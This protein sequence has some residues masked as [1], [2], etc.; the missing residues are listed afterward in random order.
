MHMKLQ[1]VRIKYLRFFESQGHTTLPSASLVPENDPTTLFTGSGMQPLLPFLLGEKHP[2]GVRLV[3]S[4]KC[5][6]AEDID[7]IGDNRHTTFFEMLGNWSLGDYFKQEQIP[8]FFEFL[9]KKIG[10]DPSKLYVTVFA[11]DKKNNI[12][13]DME[14]VELWKKLFKKHG[15]DAKDIEILTEQ[16]GGERGMQ[17]GRIFYYDAKKNWWSRAGVPD[18]MPSGEPGGPDTE[19]FYD[20]GTKHDTKYGKQCHPNCDCERFMEIGNSVFMEYIKNSDG[21]F[22]RLPQHNVDFGGGLERI[23]ATSNNNADIFKVDALDIVIKHIEKLS[24]TAYESEHLRSFRI[25]ADHLRAAVFMIADGVI[26]T[27]TEAGYFARRLL[28]RAMLHMDTLGMPKNT[29]T[30]L[31]PD[32]T[33]AYAKAYPVLQ[34]REQNIQM[35]IQEEEE[36]FR[37]TLQ[38]GLHEFQKIT[39]KEISGEAAFDLYQTYGFPIEVTEE[40]ARK[41]NVRVNRKEF[42]E[43]MKRHQEASRIGAEKKFKGGLADHSDMSVKYHTATHL[44]HQALRTVLGTHVYQKGSNITPERL[45]FDFTHGAKMTNEEKKKVEELVNQKIQE[46]LPVTYEI[47][48]I[49]EAKK[50]GAIG[51]FDDQY[52]DEVKVY[53]MGNSATGIFSMEFCGGPHV[54]NTKK[55]GEAGKFIIQKEEAVSAGVRRIKAIFKK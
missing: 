28:R 16:Q 46:A 13:R 11:G 1:D 49:E 29:L 19:V 50:R 18:N 36:R 24:N 20:F 15:I 25:I 5:F 51:L 7:E 42:D 39:T 17:G 8:W 37:K 26:P 14:A 10:L 44:L 12:S 40:L 54:E 52:G 21:T 53:Q 33:N 38:K 27:N 43:K 30:L 31:V 47:L 6:R 32:I 22:S 23:T 34:E 3:N 55:L 2:Q 41:K 45:R 35:E 4:Q 9:T 48:P